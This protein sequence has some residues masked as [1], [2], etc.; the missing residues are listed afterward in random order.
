MFAGKNVVLLVSG[1]I[2]VYKACELVRE[3]K[4][5]KA[6]V[7]VAMSTSAQEFVSALTFQ[8]LSQ[9]TVRTNLFD[10]TE[11]GVID[12]IGLADNADVVLVA[13]ATADVIARAAGGRADDIL[14]T[15]LLAT[16]SPVVFAPAMN[17]NMWLHPL[18]Q[19]NVRKLRGIGY[20]FVEPTHGELACGWVGLGRLAEIDD[21]L[22][23][24]RAA[25]TDKDLIGTEVVVTAGTTR[26]PIDP[27]RFVANRSSG[28]MGYAVARDAWRRGAKV[29]LISG[30]SSLRAP[31]GVEIINVESAVDME[32]AIFERLSRSASEGIERRLVFMVAAVS[33]HRPKDLQKQKLKAHKSKE[34]SLTMTPNPD[35]LQLIGERR[36]EL[37]N[38]AG[39]PLKLIGFAA[40]TGTEE[41]LLVAARDKLKRKRVD[42][43]VGNLAQDSIE[44]ET[45]RVWLVDSTGRQEEI[46]FAD[47][48]LVGSRIV[49]AAMRL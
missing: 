15:V 36:A 44:R 1:S 39:V 32:Q 12:H 18:T 5:Q 13:P 35:I 47:K 19:A 45:T 7:H 48:G 10:S 14:T 34:F 6:T 3:L 8:T 17:V 23:S 46:A 40:E 16:K 4:K 37:Q 24:V 29:T 2:A 25:L 41:E 9:N 28:R 27:I 20:H 30:P 26:E 42:L 11:E 31:L 38:Q 21:I 49:S 33:D 43:V 22:E